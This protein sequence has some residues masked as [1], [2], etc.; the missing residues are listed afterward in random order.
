MYCSLLNVLVSF[1][2]PLDV[3]AY[4]H[5]LIFSEMFCI[6]KNIFF[7]FF[8]SRFKLYSHIRVQCPGG[9]ML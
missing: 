5:A 8:N 3:V 6:S 1:S 7:P 2:F 4:L 9:E